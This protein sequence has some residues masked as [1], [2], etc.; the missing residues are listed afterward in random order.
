M[1]EFLK[2]L[3]AATDLSSQKLANEF[4]VQL[5]KVARNSVLFHHNIL[6]YSKLQNAV[7]SRIKRSVAPPCGKLGLAF[8]VDVLPIGFLCFSHDIFSSSGGKC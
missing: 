3:I 2:S 7:L 4:R 5:R 1:C 8:T 6:F